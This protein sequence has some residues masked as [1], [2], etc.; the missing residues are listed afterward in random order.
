MFTLDLPRISL[1]SARR[2]VDAL[3][4]KL[5]R[6]LA[7]HRLKTAVNRIVRHWEIALEKNKPGPDA[8]DCVHIVRD[9]GFR[10]ES[11][12]PLHGYID[13]CQRFR[14]TPEFGEIIGKLRPPRKMV[15][16]LNILPESAPAR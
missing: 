8:I 6:V 7:A 11:W 15:S 9:S 14:L 5:D 10:P 16:L 12:N 3:K 2:Q 1:A 4:R 13:H